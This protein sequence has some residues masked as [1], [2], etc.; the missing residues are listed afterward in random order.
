VQLLGDSVGD[1][2]PERALQEVVVE[3]AQETA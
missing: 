3:R 2:N 1:D